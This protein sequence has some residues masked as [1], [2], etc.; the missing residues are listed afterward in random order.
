MWLSRVWN[1]GL[2]HTRKTFC[3][4]RT[5]TGWDLPF[6][7][8]TEVF[9]TSAG[10]MTPTVPA[11]PPPQQLPQGDLFITTGTPST[12]KSKILKTRRG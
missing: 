6:S 1:R 7:A 3:G 10:S 8:Y 4:L 9:H 5:I 11:G 2:D 12:Y